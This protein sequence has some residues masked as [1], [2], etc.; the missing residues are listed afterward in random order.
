MTCRRLATVVDMV[1]SG[2]HELSS[3]VVSG[4]MFAPQTPKFLG[5]DDP[6]A[7]QIVQTPATP[8]F[9]TAVDFVPKAVNG[10]WSDLR[11]GFISLMVNLEIPTQLFC[12]IS[13]PIRLASSRILDA[14]TIPLRRRPWL[15]TTTIAMDRIN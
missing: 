2:V 8:G 9:Q 11:Y 10:L 13:L 5:K 14:V 3:I 12:L 7:V 1:K 15:R 6:S 4:A